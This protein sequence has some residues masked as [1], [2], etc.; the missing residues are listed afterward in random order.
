[1]PNL[2]TIS[3]CSNDARSADV[4]FVH[5]VNG[6]YINTW[7]PKGRPDEFWPAWL[8][9]DLPDV[10][11]WSLGYEARS[12]SWTGSVMP[13]ADRATH[14]LSILESNG[15]G[16]R[17]LVFIAHSLGG[18]LVKQVLRH[19]TEYGT[20][21]WEEIVSHTK[22]IV[23]LS[24]PHSAS[25]IARWLEYVGSILRPTISVN[26]LGAHDSRL[27]ELNHWFR[28]SVERL[29]IESQV[30]CE[31][32]QGGGSIVVDETSADPGIPGVSPIPMLGTHASISKPPSKDS[33]LYLHVKRFIEKVAAR[34]AGRQQPLSG[35]RLYYSY[36]HQDESLRDRLERHLSL[37]KHRGLISGWYD[38]RVAPGAEWKEE[39]DEH[40]DQADIVLFL[41]SPDLLAT[42]YCNDAE[43]KRAMKR[44]E[45]GEAM[46]VPVIL[47]PCDWGSTPFATLEVLPTDGKPITNWTD[48]EEAFV[49]VAN[50]I[51]RL[52][53]DLPK[54]RSAKSSGRQR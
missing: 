36:A 25:N 31:M 20:P 28:N 43:M 40:I 5:G 24:T 49:D 8:G 39:I 38:R 29:G 1:M 9:Q 35:A 30:I 15:L 2:I 21:A 51:H 11:I 42:E 32:G 14:V 4:V 27:R 41:V 13:L 10:G 47:R 37:L 3:N 33:Q 22:G 46:V 7:H 12:I 19:G 18:L 23:F 50:E 6:D 54:C 44:H 53:D 16:K 45:A 52:I 17:I 48:Q 26:E 34:Q